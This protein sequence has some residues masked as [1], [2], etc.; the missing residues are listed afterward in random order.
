IAA[1]E[2]REGWAGL[3][4]QYSSKL[5]AACDRAQRSILNPAE[6]Q[7]VDI[8][9]DVSMGDVKIGYRTLG[10]KISGVLREAGSA[11]FAGSGNP[12]AIVDRFRPRVRTYEAETLT[13]APFSA[14]SK[15]VEVR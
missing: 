13:H 4:S 1:R 11:R 2:H 10:A 12:D 15:T 6:W 3:K 7:I 9:E 8:A 14:Y 5:P